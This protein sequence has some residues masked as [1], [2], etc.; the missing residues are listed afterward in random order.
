[1]CWIH[2]CIRMQQRLR[3]SW[4]SGIVWKCSHHAQGLTTSLASHDQFICD[5]WLSEVSFASRR[6]SSDGVHWNDEY[7][8]PTLLVGL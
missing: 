5:T 6:T 4:S 2:S 8:L 7:H 3:T 1:M